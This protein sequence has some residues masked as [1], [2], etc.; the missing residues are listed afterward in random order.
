MKKPSAIAVLVTLVVLGT[1]SGRYLHGSI[2]GGKSIYTDYVAEVKGTTTGT[3]QFDIAIEPLIFRL[4]TMQGKYRLVRLKISNGTTTNLVLSAD[5]DSIEL[6]PH[7][8]AAVA[9]VLNPLRLDPTFWGALDQQT[10]DELTYPVMLNGIPA[11]SRGAPPSRQ[12]SLYIYLLVP[13][14]QVSEVP[15][16]FRYTIASLNQTIQIRTM[17]AAAR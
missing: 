15:E 8:G 10:R 9:A 5:R 4:E 3:Y 11:P 1:L 13:A 6:V 12:E 7:N 16:S 2:G 17:R 14:S